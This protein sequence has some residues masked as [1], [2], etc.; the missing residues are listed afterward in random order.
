M[1]TK[2]LVMVAGVCAASLTSALATPTSVTTF[3]AMPGETF[4]GNGIPNDAVQINT[5][6]TVGPFGDAVTITE[7]LSATPRFTPGELANNGAGTF[8]VAPGVQWNFDFVGTVT[9]SGLYT[10]K[11]FYDLDPA[12]GNGNL[13]EWD[14]GAP[15]VENSEFPGF[16]F[17]A[18]G[19][20]GVVTAPIGPLAYNINA[21]GEYTFALG[22]YDAN[23]APIGTLDTIHVDVGAVPDASSTAG[24]M[25]IGGLG[26]FFVNKRMTK[27]QLA[28]VKA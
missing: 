17:L 13:G 20:A 14:L 11:L 25:V 21:P 18:N 19:V 22:V 12:V 16:S 27:R 15:K 6:T 1:N 26:L 4:G 8:Y 3:G 28:V 24:L 23:G 9:G 10:F 2:L 5:I 7:G